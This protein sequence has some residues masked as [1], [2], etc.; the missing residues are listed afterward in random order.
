MLS[1][2]PENVSP[3]PTS[4]CVMF[5]IITTSLQ[6]FNTSVSR[7]SSNFCCYVDNYIICI[8]VSTLPLIS[9]TEMSFLN[10]YCTFRSISNVDLFTI[11]HVDSKRVNVT[12]DARTT[13]QD[14]EN[15]LTFSH[16]LVT[17]SAKT[18]ITSI[19]NTTLTNITVRYQSSQI[20]TSITI[21]PI[22]IVSIV[23]IKLKTYPY[24]GWSGAKPI[25]TLRHYASVSSFQKAQLQLVAI[26]N[27]V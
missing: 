9:A 18:A 12:T 15:L 4:K 25:N 27:N 14:S 6:H 20:D 23:R 19:L 26:L 8:H 16:G 10:L 21:G 13:F 1:V 11:V 2:T 3:I 17:L 7:K 5:E 22:E 24:P